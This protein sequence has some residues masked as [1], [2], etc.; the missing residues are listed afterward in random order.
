MCLFDMLGAGFYEC[1]SDTLF[2][3]VVYMLG[4]GFFE[5]LSDTLF[6]FVVYSLF[7]YNV[8]I[9]THRQQRFRILFCF[10]FNPLKNRIILKLYYLIHFFFS[11]HT[12]QYYTCL[13][14]FKL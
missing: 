10:V 9:H 4:A 12:I 8:V 5:C 6:Y 13:S 3:F 11:I 2:Y 1:L 14:T 7:S